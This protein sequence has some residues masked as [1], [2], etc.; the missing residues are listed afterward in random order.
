MQAMTERP[1]LRAAL[2]CRV[3]ERVSGAGEGGEERKEELARS[4][5]PNSPCQP[6]TCPYP[7]TNS[8]SPNAPKSPNAH[9]HPSTAGAQFHP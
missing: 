5:I 2:V 1:A 3:F 4:K 9:S 8:S 6:P 7:Q